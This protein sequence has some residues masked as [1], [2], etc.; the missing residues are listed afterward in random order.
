MSLMD[1]SLKIKQSYLPQTITRERVIVLR[2]EVVVNRGGLK[3]SI[4][5]LQRV[6][7]CLL[8]FGFFPSEVESDVD[9]INMCMS[10]RIAFE[11]KQNQYSLKSLCSALLP[12]LVGNDVEASYT[13][14][15]NEVSVISITKPAL[16]V[17]EAVYLPIGYQF[18]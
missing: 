15:Q 5:D 2:E 16:R 1:S 8:R 4:L 7:R 10:A 6:M 18:Y 3:F 13:K 17:I 11:Y 12:E 14:S 9:E